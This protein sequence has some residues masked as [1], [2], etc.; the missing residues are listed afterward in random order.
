MS[1]VFQGINLSEPPVVVSMAPA[2]H[3]RKRVETWNLPEVHALHLYQYRAELRVGTTE[4]VIAPGSVTLIPPETPITYRFPGPGCRHHY[5]IFRLPEKGGGGEGRAFPIHRP[6]HE[7][8]DGWR[9]AFAQGAEAFAGNRPFGTARLWDLLWQYV[10]TRPVRE[11][12]LPPVVADGIDRMG[13]RLHEEIRMSELA[14][15]LGVSRNLMMLRFRETLGVSPGQWLIAERM[16]R[17]KSLLVDTS[18]PVK[19]VARECGYHDLHAF[20][21]AVRQAHGKSPRALRRPSP[22]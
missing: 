17:A 20:N 15:E 2:I 11:S 16:K 4:M 3:G 8:T 21:K 7:L 22:P 14:Q 1:E 18:L 6:A 9:Q 5:A 10:G 19:I 13:R 12:H